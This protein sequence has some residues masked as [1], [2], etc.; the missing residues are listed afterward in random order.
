[1]ATQRWKLFEVGRGKFTGEVTVSSE[2][3]LLREVGKH[4][5]SRGVDIDWDDDAMTT[6]TVIVGGFR[7]VGKVIRLTA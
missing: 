2:T 1:M 6:G 3:E 5:A 7:P 4:L